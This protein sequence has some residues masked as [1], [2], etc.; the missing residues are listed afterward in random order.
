[1][2]AGN[3]NIRSI[4]IVHVMLVVLGIFRSVGSHPDQLPMRCQRSVV[5]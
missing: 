2:G 1:V 3:G 5:A 4:L